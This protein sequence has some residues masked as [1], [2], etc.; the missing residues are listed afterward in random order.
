MDSMIHHRANHYILFCKPQA[1]QVQT[2]NI[3]SDPLP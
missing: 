1:H 3:E 2:I